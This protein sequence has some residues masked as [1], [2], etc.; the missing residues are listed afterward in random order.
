MQNLLTGRQR[1]EFDLV[2]ASLDSDDRRVLEARTR[3]VFQGSVP[4]AYAAVFPKWGRGDRPMS[5][6]L[7]FDPAAMKTIRLDRRLAVAAHE[8]GHVITLR[9]PFGHMIAEAEADLFA[10]IV[11]FPK[12][13]GL[14]SYLNAQRDRPFRYQWR[15]LGDGSQILIIG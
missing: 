15:P 2:L 9:K 7:C 14:R 4:G 5:C 8:V 10:R 3:K 13:N 1:L 6:D 12:I 11:G